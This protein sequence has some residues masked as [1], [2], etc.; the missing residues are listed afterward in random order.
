MPQT[1]V[2]PRERYE[3]HGHYPAVL[4]LENRPEL[5]GRLELALFEKGFEVLHLNALGIAAAAVIDIVR[6]A[7]AMGFVAIYSAGALAAETK[8]ILASLTA[9]RVFDAATADL[10]TDDELFLQVV[11]F[12][13]SLLLEAPEEN[14]K[15]VN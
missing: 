1:H 2:A 14:R 8:R 6:V 5:A 9:D 11:T 10:S 4:L 12:A 3:R 13:R 15:R 7:E